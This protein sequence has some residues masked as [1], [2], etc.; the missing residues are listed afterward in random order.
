MASEVAFAFAGAIII[1]GFIGNYLFKKISIPDSLIL[2]A[3]G[4][5][6]GPVFG[7]IDVSSIRPIIPFFTSLALLVI[8]FDGGLNLTLD[9]VLLESPK[10]ILSALSGFLITTLGIA[11][12]MAVVFKFDLLASLLFG[13]VISDT[14]TVTILP[15]IS[16]LKVPKELTAFLSIESLFTSPL[17]I[18]VSLVII[19]LITGAGSVEGG[20]IYLDAARKIASAFSV[21]TVVGLLG[22]IAWVKIM[23]LIRNEVYNDILTLAFALLVF[24]IT[25]TLGGSGEFF[26]LI[27]GLVL[28][29]SLTIGKFF[30]MKNVVAISSVMRK[31]QTE[32]SF[33]LRTLFMVYLGLVFIVTS[34]S[35]F[36]YA[37]VITAI[38][39]AIRYVT[40][41]FSTKDDKIMYAHRNLLLVMIPRGLTVAVLSQRIVATNLPYAPFYSEL[42]IAIIIITTVVAAVGAS[43]YQYRQQRIAE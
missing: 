41:N 31:F 43:V 5:L 20:P 13:V 35:I 14:A 11:G 29:N 42:I 28:G 15:L 1:I 10:A 17:V 3:I 6:A 38:I 23:R 18:V 9:K 33:L 27:F 25:S 19:Q 4:F 12:F 22:G 26:A 2:I 8:L 37:I 7:I 36:V 21:G 30:Q 34:S 24:A 40:L 32:V 39:F 16:N